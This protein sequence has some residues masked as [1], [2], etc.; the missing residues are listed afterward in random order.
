MPA[1]INAKIEQVCL[2]VEQIGC[3]TSTG[4]AEIFSDMSQ[5]NAW[6]YL[7]R[8]C[9]LGLL[10]RSGSGEQTYKV[11]PNWRKQFNHVKLSRMDQRRENAK[12]HRDSTVQ[13]ALTHRTALEMAWR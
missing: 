11:K 13:S 7:S 5:D 12:Q 4:L 1:N 10:T 6:R 2:T 9:G 8:A 3:C